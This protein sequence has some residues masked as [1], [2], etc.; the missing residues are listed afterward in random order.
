MPPNIILTDGPVRR[1][2]RTANIHPDSW[3]KRVEQYGPLGKYPLIRKLD[4]MPTGDPADI[5]HH[6]F[7]KPFNSLTGTIT[8][9]YTTSDVVGGTGVSGTQV[10]GFT[11]YV[12]PDSTGYAKLANI[13]PYSQVEISST[14]TRKSVRGY[15]TTVHVG[16]SSNSWF[17]FTLTEADASSVLAGTGLTWSVISDGFAEIRQ[18]G[19]AVIEHET[20][21]YN[22]A[23]TFE[24]AHSLSEREFHSD[25][26]ITED[27]KMMRELDS[28]NTLDQKRERAVLEGSRLKLG[29]RYYAGGLRWFLT[30]YE[31]GNI[32]D[33]RTDTTYSAST[34]TPLGGTIDFIKNLSVYLRQWSDPNEKKQLLC[35]A[36][37]RSFL[38]QCV[39]NSGVYQIGSETN[40]FGLNV[41]ML[42]GLDQPIEIVE[43]PLLNTDD[44][45]KYRAYLIEPARLQR[46]PTK[47]GALKL[48]PWSTFEDAS[49]R[50]ATYIEGGWRAEETYQWNRLA[51]HAIIENISLA[52][53]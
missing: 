20:E 52:K 39:M 5:I 16:T 47:N 42:R 1:G 49:R 36:T 24:E 41:T 22:Y 2:D 25:S 3:D 33:W 6:W 50:H 19:T 12:K 34:D 32:I 30:Q 10:S 27:K 44:A 8:D 35:S 48:L 51:T 21:Y 53:A 13:K 45:A 7:E 38:D 40:E 15:V 17:D 28:R 14:S 18:L 43:E 31:S 4:N 23:G 46:R 26:R 11:C 9:I 29:D 37:V